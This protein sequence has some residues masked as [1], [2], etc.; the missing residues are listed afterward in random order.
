MNDITVQSCHNMYKRVNQH[1]HMKV[2]KCITVERKPSKTESL[3]SRHT[4]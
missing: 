4:V 1:V 3:H 2:A